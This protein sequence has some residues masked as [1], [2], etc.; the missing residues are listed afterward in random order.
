V[1]FLWSTL[2]RFSKTSFTKGKRVIKILLKI[3]AHRQPFTGLHFWAS[4]DC[5][6]TIG[7][8]QKTIRN[9]AKIKSWLNH[10]RMDI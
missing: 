8:D 7:L 1:L 6:S 10:R 5:A 9:Y 3:I 2:F 4:G